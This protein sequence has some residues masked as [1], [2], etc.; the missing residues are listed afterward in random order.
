MATRK[1]MAG[2]VGARDPELTLS[3]V[4]RR[5]VTDGKYHADGSLKTKDYE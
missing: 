5:F 2:P 4:F 3:E 1:R